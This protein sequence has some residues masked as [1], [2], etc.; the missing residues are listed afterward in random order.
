MNCPWCEQT[1]DDKLIRSLTKVPTPCPMCGQLI[2]EALLQVL[3]VAIVIM[4][5]V[6]GVLVLSYFVD[7][8][9]YRDRA[10]AIFLIGLA[11]GIFVQKYIPVIAQP[12][13]VK[14]RE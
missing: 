14:P 10:I 1:L 12:T 8:Q 7:E 3:F 5:V 2:R 6:A 4:P 13:P 11:A 9:G